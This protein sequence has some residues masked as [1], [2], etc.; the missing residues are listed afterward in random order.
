MILL[1]LG[2]VL[3]PIDLIPDFIPILGHL[4]DLLIVPML[5]FLSLR[6]IPVKIKEEAREKAA[7]EP[8]QWK[9]NWI[10]GVLFLLIWVGIIVGICFFLIKLFF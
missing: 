1:T 7:R 6:C 5:I 4:D 3:S 10:V 9:K 2:Y 8:L